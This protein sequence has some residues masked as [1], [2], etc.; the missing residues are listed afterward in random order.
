MQG[1]YI[2]FENK[3]KKI[4]NN[5]IQMGTGKPTDD[6]NNNQNDNS[7]NNQDGNQGNSNNN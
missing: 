3:C 1:E 7:E 5:V 2:C 6:S 4:V